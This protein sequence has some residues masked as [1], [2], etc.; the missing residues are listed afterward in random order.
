MKEFLS[1][2]VKI[3]ITDLLALIITFASFGFLFALLWVKIP[4]SNKD[5]TNITIGFVL[6]SFVA[7]VAGFYFGASKKDSTEVKP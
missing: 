6:G 2:L 5:I 7:G 4:D 3:K 1:N